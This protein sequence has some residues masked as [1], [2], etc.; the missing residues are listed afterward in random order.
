LIVPRR[1]VG[2]RVLAV[3]TSEIVPPYPDRPTEGFLNLNVEFSPMASPNADVRTPPPPFLVTNHPA[4]HFG[5][6]R[7]CVVPMTNRILHVCPLTHSNAR[8]DPP[9][10]A[11]APRCGTLCRTRAP[12]R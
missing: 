8:L 1:G 4:P 10:G 6:I 2:F 12:R 11:D 7:F 9:L 5:S 3:V